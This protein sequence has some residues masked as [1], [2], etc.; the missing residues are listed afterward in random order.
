M[1][2][3]RDEFASFQAYAESRLACGDLSVSL[4]ELFA[5]WHDT[6]CR[7]EID[8]AIRRGLADMESG[9]YR[10]AEESLE[11]IRQ[12]FGFRQP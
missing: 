4:D 12:E 9:R 10:S 8:A 3:T 6:Q 11:N 1:S 7:D 2:S 5:E